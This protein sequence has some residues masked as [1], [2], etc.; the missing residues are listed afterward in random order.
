MLDYR[1]CDE[2][3]N[4][5]IMKRTIMRIKIDERTLINALLQQKLSEFNKR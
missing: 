3:R 2:Y 4:L 5:Q 1:A